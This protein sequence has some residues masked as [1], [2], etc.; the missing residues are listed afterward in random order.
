MPHLQAGLDSL[1]AVDL[2]N[3]LS[4]AFATD[5]LPAT[6]AFDYPTTA[7]LAQLLWSLQ[8]QPAVRQVHKDLT[9][10]RRVKL[11]ELNC[12]LKM[13]AG[14]WSLEDHASCNELGDKCVICFRVRRR[15]TPGSRATS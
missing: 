3:L 8:P 13:L 7:A 12:I 15:H 1:G 11:C 6:L 14:P 5:E 4:S 2:R 9:A 10:L